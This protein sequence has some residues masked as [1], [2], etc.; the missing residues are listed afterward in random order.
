MKEETEMH[1]FPERSFAIRYK[2]MVIVLP[3]DEAEFYSIAPLERWE[4]LDKAGR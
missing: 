1:A 3:M 4:M 2:N